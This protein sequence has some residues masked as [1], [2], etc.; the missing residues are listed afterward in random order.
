MKA[1]KN[2]SFALLAGLALLTS[3]GSDG[4][5]GPKTEYDRQA[6]LTNYAENLIVPGY[7]SFK[8]EAAEMATAVSA[9]TANP[10]TAA[11]ATARK[12]YLDAYKE[13]QKVSMYE[14]GPADEQMLRTNLNIFPTTTSQIENNISSGTY[15]LQTTANMSAKGFPALDY[16]LYTNASDAEVVA[17]YTS[18]PNAANRKKYLQDI[19]NLIKQRAEA[20]Y[21]TWTTNNY[22]QT[23]KAA[24]GTAVGSAVGNL[25]NQLNFDIDVTKRA[26]VGIPSGRFTAGSALPEKVEAFYSKTSLELLKEAIRAEKAVFMGQS[27]SGANGPGLD[28]Y[29]DHVGAMYN[30]GLLSEAIEAQFDA[31]LAAA[32]AVQGPLS[33]AVTAQPQAVTKLYDELQKLIVLTKTDMPSAL[34]VAI[35]Y[36]DNDGD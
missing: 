33:V 21:S 1:L 24:A 31:A 16:L 15:D 8:T 32:N 2:Y 19:T 36:T 26:K 3:C 34:G 20:T 6:M 7:Q 13:W 17:L 22:S 23:F 27:A 10:S 4:E 35:T 5:S 28:D 18:A 29:L 25:V 30:G 12:E 11:L 9:F 14:F